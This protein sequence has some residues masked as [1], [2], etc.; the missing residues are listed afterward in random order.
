MRQDQGN[1]DYTIATDSN[2]LD[3]I[4]SNGIGHTDLIYDEN[5]NLINEND[6]KAIDTEETNNY[7]KD[8]TWDYENRLMSVSID[9][10]DKIFTVNFAYN[11]DGQRISKKVST[12]KDDAVKIESQILYVRNSF[13]EVVEEHSLDLSS[14]IYHLSSSYVF[15]NGKRIMGITVKE[16]ETPGTTVEEKTYYL[17][18]ILGSNSLLTDIDGNPTMLTKYDEFG[19]T[20][21]EWSLT[22]NLQPPTSQYKYTG[23]PFDSEIGLYYY[24]ARYYNPQLGR[25]VSKDL[26]GGKIEKTQSVSRYHFNFNNPLRYIDLDGFVSDEQFKLKEFNEHLRNPNHAI[27]CSR[28]YQQIKDAKNEGKG[29]IKIKSVFWTIF[30]TTITISDLKEKSILQATIE[31]GLKYEEWE[32]NLTPDD[33][34]EEYEDYKNPRNLMKYAKLQQGLAMAH[35]SGSI[36]HDCRSFF[37]GLPRR[38]LDMKNNF[39]GARMEELAPS[40]DAKLEDVRKAYKQAVKEYEESMKSITEGNIGGYDFYQIDNSKETYY[41]EK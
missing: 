36:K 5:G 1:F 39:L 21:Y 35:M 40:Q 14:N 30:E 3:K 29:E 33:L 38:I 8:F 27:T 6:Y 41:D 15:G 25:W 17:S 26:L 10:D 28:I 20:Y 4:I 23:K 19:N 32:K 12:K 37:S 13:G 11:G 2:Q 34:R 31:Y 16:G 24:G 18:D 9:R 7:R 22:S